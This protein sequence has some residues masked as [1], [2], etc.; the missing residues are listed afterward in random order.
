MAAACGA[1]G[2]ADDVVQVGARR[3]EGLPL[4]VEELLS[5]PV[6][7]LSYR[8]GDAEGSFWRGASPVRAGRPLRAERCRHRLAG[9]HRPELTVAGANL[10]RAPGAVPTPAA[11]DRV[12]GAGTGEDQDRDPPR[13]AHLA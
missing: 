3:S 6:A 1:A 11:H 2:L 9:V 13:N 4:L 8:T 7:G 12:D 10:D 5:V